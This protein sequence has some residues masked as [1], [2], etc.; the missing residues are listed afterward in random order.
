MKH[1]IKVTLLFLLIL[2]FPSCSS[3]DS[4]ATN[5]N[6]R[7]DYYSGGGF[8][9]ME[10]GVTIS[11]EGWVKFWKQSLNSIRQ[12]TDSVSLSSEQQKR[13]NQLMNN[14]ELFSY[15]NKF[16]GNYT[17]YLVLMK[18]V[19]FNRMSFNEADPPEN[20]PAA[21]KDLILEIKNINKGAQR[22]EN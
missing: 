18:D 11:C 1:F 3:S 16:A 4:C 6:Y 13:F 19:Q 5:G 9:G 2:P 21:I 7:I 10:S 8:T 17:T 22:H 15:Q 14:P 12:T 20:L